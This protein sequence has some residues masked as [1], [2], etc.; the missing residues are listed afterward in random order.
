MTDNAALQETTAA[1]TID[2]RPGTAELAATARYDFTK[3]WTGDM[4]GVSTGI[5]LSAGDPGSGTA[6]YV[7][8]ET[9]DGVIAGRRGTVVLQQ[10]G[11]MSDATILYYEFV[12]GSASGELTGLTGT[13]TL[14][15]DHQ[16]VVRHRLP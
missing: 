11:T 8:M 1:F 2:L 12:P 7:A 6:G 16:V 13:L 10:F 5:M 14:G 4:S 3:T 15:E 9:F